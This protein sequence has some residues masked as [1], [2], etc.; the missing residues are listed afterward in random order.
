MQKYVNEGSRVIF[1][2]LQALTKDIGGNARA[3][4]GCAIG[5]VA[6]VLLS[7]VFLQVTWAIRHT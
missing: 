4:E 3:P 2:L 6:V 1:L 7:A 5:D